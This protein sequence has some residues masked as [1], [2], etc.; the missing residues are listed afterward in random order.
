MTVVLYCGWKKVEEDVAVARAVN[1]AVTAAATEMAV[2]AASTSA[3]RSTWM[4]SVDVEMEIFDYSVSKDEVVDDCI[5]CLSNY[6]EDEQSAL[7]LPLCRHKF[8]VACIQRWLECY[9]RCPIGGMTPIPSQLV[10]QTSTDVV[11]IYVAV[12]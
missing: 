9:G 6:E 8:Y 2:A 5:I 3:L 1:V 4:Q 12:S 7:L 11:H 10:S